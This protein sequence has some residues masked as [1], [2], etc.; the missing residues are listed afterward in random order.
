M[1]DDAEN[2]PEAWTWAGLLAH[3]FTP[4]P[5]FGSINHCTVAM[6]PHTQFS[7]GLKLERVENCGR[8]SILLPHTRLR[9]MGA[10]KCFHFII[11]S[12]YRLLIAFLILSYPPLSPLIK[13][14]GVKLQNFSVVAPH[15]NLATLFA[16]VESE[17]ILT[18][19]SECGPQ[20]ANVIPLSFVF[21]AAVLIAIF[22]A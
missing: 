19:G 11:S 10:K 15:T 2:D 18:Y 3:R 1:D 6:L 9:P 5:G 4:A 16:I 21:T 22:R 7:H 8:S 14:K 20:P 13:V 17:N 12:P